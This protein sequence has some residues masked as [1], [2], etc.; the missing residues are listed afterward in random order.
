MA[1]QQ[2]RGTTLVEYLAEWMTSVRP[3]LRE[4]TWD[5][6]AQVVQGHLVP[7]LGDLELSEITPKVLSSFYGKLLAS[8]RQDGKGGLSAGTARY[9]HIV[10]KKA[11]SDAARWGEIDRNPC[12]LV[13]GPRPRRPEMRTWTAEQVK[14]FLTHV[15]DDRLWA[16][17]LLAA[18]TGM[19]RG[20]VLGL[21][22]TDL[23]LEA[24]RLQ[25]R[26]ALVSVRYRIVVSEPKTARGRRSVDLDPASVAALEEHRDRMRGE[27]EARRAELSDRD[28]V[29]VGRAGEPI[30]PDR[31]YRAFRRHSDRAGL[32]AIRLH[33]LRHTYASVALAAGIHPKVV[34]E[35]L[36]HANIMITLDTYSHVIPSLQ[37]EAAD[38]VAAMIVPD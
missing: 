28:L 20:E 37:R 24:G 8:G 32:P 25:V 38:Q 2:E 26:R 5:S 33:D 7:G 35:R 11:L 21:R 6:Y 22:W 27:F 10:L 31:F 12:D 1:I 15:R 36:G 14:T 9:C 4:S 30:H 18:T 13:S 16:A 19:R 17:W 23:D 3:T 34:S 29:F